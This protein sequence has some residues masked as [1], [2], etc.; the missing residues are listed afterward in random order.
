M[1]GI[2][3]RGVSR[4][5]CVLAHLPPVDASEALRHGGFSVQNDLHIVRALQILHQGRIGQHGGQSAR[6]CAGTA[7]PAVVSFQV[8]EELLHEI[9]G[10]LRLNLNASVSAMNGYRVG[11]ELVL[12]FVDLSDHFPVGLVGV[13]EM[14]DRSA[15]SESGHLLP[16]GLEIRFAR[17]LEA[18]LGVWQG[19]AHRLAELFE[20]DHSVLHQRRDV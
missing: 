19:D 7:S 14:P 13:R 20:H 11:K 5:F 16:D 4:V 1:S 10:A 9:V 15:V 8:S 2:F 17:V 12:V 6:Q 3:L 18:A